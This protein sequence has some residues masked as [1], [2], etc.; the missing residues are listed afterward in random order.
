MLVWRLL[1]GAAF[2]AGLVGIC[3]LDAQQYQG[4]PAGSWLFPLALLICVGATEEML[5]LVGLWDDWPLNMLVFAVNLAIVAAGAVAVASPELRAAAPTERVGWLAV[6]LVIGVLLTMVLE[7]G[8]FTGPGEVASRI[9]RATLSMV[10]VGLT[11]GFLVEL[12]L[13]RDNW[14][15]MTALVSVVATV[16]F[17]DTAAYF[18]GRLIGRHKMTPALSPGKTWEGAVGGLLFAPL[19]TWI[20]F[21]LLMPVSSAQLEMV[22]QQRWIIYGVIVAVVGLIGDLAESLL[23]RDAGVKNSS[24]WMPGFGGVLDV[25][26]SIIFAAPVAWL[27]WVVGLV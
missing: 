13:L 6:P 8:R 9:A 16:K 26:D 14:Q 24:A 5:R 21:R 27:L 7:I 17:G 20:T 19:A 12:R 1:L 4:A 15:G 23:K 2:I 11:M 10:Y 3:F 25:I 18:V 22:T